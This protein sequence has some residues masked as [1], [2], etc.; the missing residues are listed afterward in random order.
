MHLWSFYAFH[1]KRKLCKV[2]AKGSGT[3][4]F[5]NLLV[6]KMYRIEFLKFTQ[7]RLDG[8][9][10]DN[11]LETH[12]SRRAFIGSR[13]LRRAFNHRRRD[14]RT[15]AI[16]R[17]EELHKRWHHERLRKRREEILIIDEE[18]NFPK[19]KV[20]DSCTQIFMFLDKLRRFCITTA[21]ARLQRLIYSIAPNDKNSI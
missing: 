6:S 2:K 1:V 17:R 12:I 21:S 11:K 7:L 13:K 19:V 4:L 16:R 9:H 18:I 15:L 10:F 8:L 20:K 3:Q 14:F 5:C